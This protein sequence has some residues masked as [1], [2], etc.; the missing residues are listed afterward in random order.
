M[1]VNQVN[2]AVTI[3]Q[4]GGVIAYSTDTVMGL[5]CDPGNRTAVERILWLKRRGEEKGLI[6]LTADL[7]VLKE[8]SQPLSE[9]QMAKISSSSAEKPI[10]WL[11]PASRSTPAWIKGKHDHVAIRL[12]RH[13]VASELCK[14][15]GAIVSTSANFSGYPVVEQKQHLR[16]WFGPHLDYV[17]TGVPGTG[18]PS[19]I[20]DLVSGEVVR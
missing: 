8:F 4:Q 14:S 17:I 9:T 6:V 18:V 10:T 13:P 15:N 2:Q 12:T 1:S 20:R 19:E 5:G 7:D 16:S 3:I 11:L